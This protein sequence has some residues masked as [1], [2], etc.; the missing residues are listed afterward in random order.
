MVFGLSCFILRAATGFFVLAFT[1][2][3]P[4]LFAAK[5]VV[6]NPITAANIN[7]INFFMIYLLSLFL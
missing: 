1:P 7:P 6:P 3:S 5:A 2:L 4:L